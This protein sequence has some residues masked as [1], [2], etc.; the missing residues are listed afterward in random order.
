MHE[1]ANQHDLTLSWSEQDARIIAQNFDITKLPDGF[2]ANPCPYY[3]TLQ[4]YDPVH[5]NPDGSY[6]L[7]RYNDVAALYRDKRLTSDKQHLFRPRFGESPAYQHHTTSLVFNDPPYHTRVR[8]SIMGAL[9]PRAIRAM[10]PG[11][12]ELVE[13][14]LDKAE[15]KGEFDLIDDYA[16]AIPVEVI[17]NLLR[18]PHADRGPLRGWSIDILSVLEPAVTPELLE[19]GN[20]AVEDFSDYLRGLIADRRNHLSDDKTD[21]LSRLIIG[22]PNGEKLTED[23]LI[24]NCIFLLNAGHETTTNLI[25]N[26]IVTLLQHPAERQRLQQDHT[27]IQSTIEECLRYESPNQ[28]GNREVAEPITIGEIDLPVGTQIILGIGAANRD[29]EQFSNSDRF[30]IARTP[31]NHLAFAAGIHACAGMS[32]ARLEGQI[33]IARIFSRFPRLRILDTPVLRQ[34]VRFRGYGSVPVGV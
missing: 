34:R 14:L 1:A 32:L 2:I 22:T 25:G 18:V 30:D 17:G 11:L 29:P 27:L 24:H 26:G 8:N 4:I 10:E 20:R 21:V 6:L 28:I 7:T 9:Q 16:A 5:R 23:E 13:G 33:A 31:N 15:Q 12:I 19:R 3:R